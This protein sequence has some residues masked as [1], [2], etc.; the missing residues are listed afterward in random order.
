MS[1]SSDATMK[2]VKVPTFNGKK[3][4]FQTWWIRFKAFANAYGF[5]PALSAKAE[6]DLPTAEDN[7]V[8]INVDQQAAVKR[9]NMAVY[10]LTLAF[11]TDE[12]M[13]F[14]HKGISEE[15]PS[16]LAWLIVKAL[17]ARFKPQYTIS[18]YEFSKALWSIKMESKESPDVRF[19]RIAS[20]KSYYGV[21]DFDEQQ[22]IAKGATRRL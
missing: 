13:E 16:G 21:L 12:A 22:L 19:S 5:L 9:N 20:L 3:E 15:H 2:S 1:D 14:Y 8:E 17:H 10:Y 18:T 4:A 6:K 7:E 11:T